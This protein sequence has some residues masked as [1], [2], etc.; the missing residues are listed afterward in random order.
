MS[1]KR[2]AYLAL[3]LGVL[4]VAW[5]AT[6]VKLA[7][8]PGPV[9]AFYRLLFASLILLPWQAPHLPLRA[10]PTLSALAV[11][12]GVLFALNAVL[13][14]TSLLLTTAANSTVLANT[15]PLWVGLGTLG[16][17]RQRLP[18]LFWP[19]LAVAFGGV[20]LLLGRDLLVNPRFGLGDLLAMAAA[21]LYA[22]SLLITQRVRQQL[23]AFVV[24]TLMAASGVVILLL[25]C[26]AL[27]A[28]LAGYP[29]RTWLAL[30]ALGLVSHVG[31]LVATN[32]ALPVI[33][34]AAV[35]VT[36]L[37][38][39]ALSATIAAVVLG[40]TLA[41]LQLVGGALV[42]GGVWLVHRR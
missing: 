36:M 19:G 4:C 39:S 30:L 32:Y 13:W 20:T 18:R 10:R 33:G 42:L 27:G 21:V 38:Q 9:S 16:L 17:F 40:E 22:A 34:A 14:N 1:D 6:L 25:L 26:L 37:G 7:S 11:A 28:P 41:P 31:G 35:S 24:T 29:L 2:R 23:N 15:A 12:G 5:S 8:V 3:G